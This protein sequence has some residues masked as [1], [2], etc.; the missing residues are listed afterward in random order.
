MSALTDAVAEKVAAAPKPAPVAVVSLDPFPTDGSVKTL[1][2]GVIDWAEGYLLQPD[3]DDAGDPFRFTREQLNFI[4]WWYA[5]DAGG[6]FIYRR[7][8]L[9]RAKGWGKSPF[10]GALALAELAGPVR[11][12]GWSSFGDPVGVTHPMPWIVIAGVSETQTENT[13]AAIRAMCEDSVLVDD[14]GLDVGMTRI[15]LPG[16]GK[17]VPITAS[18]SSQEGAR[19]TF[20]IMDE[21]HHWTVSNGGQKLARVVRRNL[22]KARDGAARVVETTNAHEPGQESVAEKS[23]MAWRAIVEGRSRSTGIL[24]DTREAP[25]DIDLADEAQV[26]AGLR[27]AYGDA[28]WVDLDRILAEVYDP[29]T[30]PEEARRF[31]LNQIVAA[32]D[33]WVAPAEWGKNR[34]PD[35][36]PLKFGTPGSK[37]D[38]GD[39]VTLG[40]D[41]SLTDDSTALVACRVDDGAVFLLAIWERPEGPKGQGWE[42]PKDQVRGAVDHAFASLDVVAFFSD[43]AY[44]E[45]DIDAWRDEYAERLLVKATTR[46]AVGFDMRGHQMDTTRAVEAT[47]RAITDGELP[48]TAHGLLAGSAPEA[49]ADEILTRHVLNARRRPN[50]WGVSFGKETRESPKKVDALASLV[51]ARMARSRVMAEGGLKKRRKPAGRVAGF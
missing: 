43:V 24:Y 47:H 51:L 28:S 12:G 11:F 13:F 36:A 50:R 33:S 23:Y 45:T 6:V 29:D 14:F 26:M 1:G 3:G 10:L 30:P 38:R 39:L 19:P 37:R 15:L 2:W 5:V 8:I 9:R 41:G 22:A 4:L 42:V 7:G 27:C 48:W 20:A 16:G 44:W 17:I 40:F 25:D 34:A 35:L 18:S 32:A 46:H 49:K 21:T 31:Y